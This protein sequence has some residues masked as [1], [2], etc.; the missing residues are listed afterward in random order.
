MTNSSDSLPLLEAAQNGYVSY[1]LLKY[2]AARAALS[3]PDL[4]DQLSCFIASQ[5]AANEINFEEEDTV[6]NSLWTVCV[7]DEFWTDHEQ[8][9]PHITN[10]VYLAF[11]AGEYHRKSDPVGTDPESKYTRPLIE[12]LLAKHNHTGL[13]PP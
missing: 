9:I 5:Y 13:K 7:S 4:L 11:D 1:T 8:T 6:M 12:A 3:A 10:T 2:A